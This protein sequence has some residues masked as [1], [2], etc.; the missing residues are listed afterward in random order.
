MARA[1]QQ[2]LP[3][4]ALTLAAMI[5]ALTFVACGGSSSK[6]AS[7]PTASGGK[8]TQTSETSASVASACGDYKAGQGGIIQVFCGGPATAKVTMGTTTRDL[9]GGSCGEQAGGFGIDFGAVAGPAYPSGKAKPDYL[10]ATIDDRSGAVIAFTINL[11][12]TSNGLITN[13]TATISADKKTATLTGTQLQGGE[14]VRVD[15]SC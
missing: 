2:F 15:V 1:P 3:V 11:N 6:G 10:G 9:T 13:G 14:A 7:A 12:G 4:A 8:A 5:A